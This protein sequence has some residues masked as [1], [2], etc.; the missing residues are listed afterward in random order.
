[1]ENISILSE[2]D[3]SFIYSRK[4][5][6]L[7]PSGAKE[8]QYLI[9]KLGQT[10]IQKALKQSQGIGRLLQQY[11]N[12]Y[13]QLVRRKGKLTFEDTQRLLGPSNNIQL[14]Q[15]DATDRLMI[16]Y[17]LDGKYKHWLL[18]EFQDTNDVQWAVCKDLADEVIQSPEG[19]RSFFYVGEPPPPPGPPFFN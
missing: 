11:E 12:K 15:N 8:L 19:D 18:D 9:Y 1:M 2:P 5:L 16:N 4:K 14:S 17:R 6:S 3:Y 10:E 7:P 13:D